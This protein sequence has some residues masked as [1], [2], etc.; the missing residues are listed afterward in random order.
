MQWA[1]EP[2]GSISVYDAWAGP[3]GYNLSGGPNGDEDGDGFSNF[4]EFA[5]GMNP[6]A[7]DAPRPVTMEYAGDSLLVGFQRARDS[8]LNYTVWASTDLVEWSPQ[9]VVSKRLVKT[10]DSRAEII[11]ATVFDP[12]SAPVFFLRVHVE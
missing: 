5:F 9:N 7:A 3:S 11:E 12:P 8:G 2:V 10:I 1:I 6:T 4:F